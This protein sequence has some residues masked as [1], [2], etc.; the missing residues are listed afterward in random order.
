MVENNEEGEED[1]LV[2]S[3]GSK[4]PS[5]EENKCEKRGSRCPSSSSWEAHGTYHATT[6]S[7][8]TF[9]TT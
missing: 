5:E 4:D 3:D 8:S 9:Y 6:P 1:A 7:S 2:N